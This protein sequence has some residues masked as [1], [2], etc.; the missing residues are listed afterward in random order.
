MLWAE[1]N[2]RDS[3]FEALQRKE[4]Y[5]TSGT[6]PVIRFFG[7]FDLPADICDIADGDEMISTAYDTG[8]PMGGDLTPPGDGRVPRFMITAVMDQISGS[9]FQ[10]V[11]I[12]KGWVDGSGANEEVISVLPV[13][14]TASVNVETCEPVNA[15]RGRESLCQVW[16]DE[17]FDAEENAFLLR[18]SQENPSCRWHSYQC[19]AAGLTPSACDAGAE[20]P[21][22]FEKCCDYVYPP[23]TALVG[24]ENQRPEAL[25]KTQQERAWTTPIWYQV[26]D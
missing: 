26:E 14:P 9:R 7:G 20:I 4:V 23:D 3:L 13:G 8:V 2:T 18:E 19:N 10:E 1:E 16:E 11:E 25:P 5:G 21:A 22:G 15:D 24:T 12:I 17:D 6:R